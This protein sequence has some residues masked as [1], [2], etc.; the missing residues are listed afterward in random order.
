M[1]E[2]LRSELDSLLGE[3]DRSGVN[4]Y[5]LQPRLSR[6]LVAIAQE[7]GQVPKEL[8]RLER[9]LSEEAAEARFDNLPV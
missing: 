1:S 2:T 3:I 7:A 6:L 5:L 4:R 9:D 8:T